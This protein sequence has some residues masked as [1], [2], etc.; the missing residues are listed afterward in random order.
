MWRVIDAA[1]RAA[2]VG[3]EAPVPLASE[4]IDA[5]GRVPA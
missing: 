1:P 5:Q 2:V 3:G 4:V